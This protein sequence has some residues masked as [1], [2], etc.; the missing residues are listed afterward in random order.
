MAAPCR[1]KAAAHG[2]EGKVRQPTRRPVRHD[3]HIGA[4]QQDED[5]HGAATGKHM[6]ITHRKLRKTNYAW[7]A[8]AALL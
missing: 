7:A 1:S 6:S 2:L 3:Q 5:G 8:L 4:Y